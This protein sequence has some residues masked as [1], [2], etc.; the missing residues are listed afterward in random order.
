MTTTTDSHAQSLTHC[1]L[2]KRS[3]AL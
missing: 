1:C 3:C 2:L